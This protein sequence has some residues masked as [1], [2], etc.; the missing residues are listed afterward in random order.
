MDGA[1][2]TVPIE[3]LSEG[4]LKGYSEALNLHLGWER[5]Q[6]GWCEPAT[7]GHILTYDDQRDRADSK[8]EARVQVEA[9][10]RELEAEVRRLRE[11]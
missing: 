11:G 7:G 6:L 8:P 3:E 10:V 1:Y 4:V 2:A 5:G 9:M